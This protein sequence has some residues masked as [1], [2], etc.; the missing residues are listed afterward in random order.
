MALSAFNKTLMLQIQLINKLQQ[1]HIAVVFINYGT[2][3]VSGLLRAEG[4]LFNEVP[5]TL[6]EPN[7]EMFSAIQEQFDFKQALADGKKRYIDFISDDA[8]VNFLTFKIRNGKNLTKRPSQFHKKWP[9]EEKFSLE[10]RER[11][12]CFSEIVDIN[13]TFADLIVIKNDPIFPVMDYLVPLEGSPQMISHF[14]LVGN[15][16]PHWENREMFDK[17]GD[18]TF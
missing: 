9:S 14:A 13:S 8:S 2:G 10:E 11:Y 4:A 18:L 1:A 3:G 7:I 17:V 15:F 6:F 16:V 5:R 12:R